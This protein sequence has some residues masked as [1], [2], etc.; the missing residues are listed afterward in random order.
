MYIGLYFG[1][2][3]ATRTKEA[4]A[5][6]QRKLEY[7]RESMANLLAYEALRRSEKVQVAKRSSDDAENKDEK[8]KE[9]KPADARKLFEVIFDDVENSPI[10]AIGVAPDDAAFLQVKA[11][12]KAKAAEELQTTISRTLASL[13]SPAITA[14]ADELKDDL[15]SYKVR[16]YRDGLKLTKE[17]KFCKDSL[18][19]HFGKSFVPNDLLDN[20]Q[21][22]QKEGA[23]RR[24]QARAQILTIVSPLFK[25]LAVGVGL[26]MAT[27][28]F[29]GG[30]S[31]SY[32]MSLPA[33]LTATINADTMRR[34]F[35]ECVA[36][37]FAY[38]LVLPPDIYGDVLIDDVQSEVSLKLRSAIMATVLAQDREYFDLHQV[39]ELQER[40]NR[41]T[42][43]VSR[44]LVAV[45]KRMLVDISRLITNVVIL[46]SLSYRLTGMALALPVP[47]SIGVG[48]LAMK[49]IRRQNRKIGRVNDRAA[50]GS[51]EVLRELTT[52]RQAGMERAEV[53]HYVEV[54]TWRMQ[55]ERRLRV[56]AMISRYTLIQT[57][58][59]NRALNLYVGVLLVV[60][61][62]LLAT[63][64]LMAVINIQIIGYTARSL[65]DQGPQ[66][67]QVLEPLNR[68]ANLL[69]SRPKIEPLPERY[70]L[71]A[72]SES[73]KKTK[74][75]LGRRPPKFVGNFVFEDVHFAYPTEKQKRVLNGLSFEV[76]PRQKVALVGSAGCGKSTT[77]QLVQRFYEQL[78]GKI[79]L[80]GHPLADYDLHYLRAHIGVVAQDNVLFSKSIYHNITYGMGHSGLPPPTMEMVRAATDAANA[81]EFIDEF[82]DGFATLV[83]EKGI[84]LSGGQKQRV[85]I[86]RAIIRQPPILILD[87]A[88]SAL[89]SVNEKVVQ[90]ALDSMLRAHNGVA[91]VI[92]HK[93]T[94]IKNCDKIVVIDKGVKVEEGTHAELVKIPVKHTAKD[95]FEA[96]DKKPTK[97]GVIGG[98]Y[99]NL[100]DTQMGE[101]TSSYEIETASAEEAHERLQVLQR[102][103]KDK[104]AELCKWEKAQKAGEGTQ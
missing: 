53:S 29:F 82:P 17:V 32:S 67:F 61:G 59:F 46:S 90:K 12:L 91:L 35:V 34:T 8:K 49:M 28:T 86:A 97:P 71:V 81:T 80:D 40:L 102:S 57:V 65:F 24:K 75:N 2:L 73:P 25:K 39:G 100:W 47:M 83:G 84:K 43:E 10:T 11:M 45:P 92:A 33:K 19:V 50:A 87:E 9:K 4:E 7:A 1:K 16:D 42:E 68:L 14:A 96:M 104:S 36:L 23:S 21:K 30:F 48:L 18:L 93:L 3:R 95:D 88:T 22:I 52:V 31:Y 27:E 77:I 6:D 58:M 69:E 38:F 103:L 63:K 74:P 72:V 66:I 26:R 54:A 79:L 60:S 41:D 101:E 78:S 94:T 56:T 99:H 55:L 20:A 70:S 44:M 13:D 89:D 15:G 98:H 62:N 51:I 76:G 85:A 37:G 5:E 64:L